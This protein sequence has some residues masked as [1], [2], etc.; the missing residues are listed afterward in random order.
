MSITAVQSES[1]AS[2]VGRSRRSTSTP[3]T[4]IPATVA[5][6]NTS[7]TRPVR[8]NPACA[9]NGATYVYIT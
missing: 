8:P 3:V 2:R 7:S 6:P 1:A 5:A 4:Q 9:A